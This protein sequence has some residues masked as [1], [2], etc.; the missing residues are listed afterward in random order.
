MILEILAVALPCA[1]TWAV[2]TGP[3]G[4]PAGPLDSLSIAQCIEMARA[5]APDVMAAA[6]DLQ[7]AR[8]DSSAAMLN[9]LPTASL[10]GSVMIAPRGFYDP[11][12]T[13]LGQYEFKAGVTVPLLDSG[14]AA[15]ER[16]RAANE[17]ALATLRMRS[18]SREAGL[19]AGKLA[20]EAL[21]RL[22]R[23]RF[24][25]ESLAWIE[26]FARIIASRVRAGVSAPSDSMRINIERD[27]VA[28]SLDST[29]TGLHVARRELA[30]LLGLSVEALPPI[31][32]SMSLEDLGPTTA[33]S[34]ALVS[35]VVRHPD[36][37]IAQAEEAQARLDVAELRHQDD[38]HVGLSGDAGIAG[39]DLTTWTPVDLRAEEPN[40]TFDDRLRRDLGVSATID[41]RRGLVDPTRGPAIA[42]RRS[43]EKAAHLRSSNALNAQERAALDILDRWRAAVRGLLT[44]R[45]IVERS[46]LNLLRTKSLYIAGSAG[47]LDILDARRTLDD[48]HERLVD[49]R[50]LSRTARIE[51]ETLP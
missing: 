21:T 39:T 47:M 35:R 5:N 11:T 2:G 25:T 38:L 17:A 16:A 22:E 14:A 28:A 9:S 42:A 15:R 44:T 4:A 7:A 30:S 18:I 13:D 37:A 48:A 33:D 51:A 23:E 40:P 10:F 46:E 27:M 32:E 50:S 6:A 26:D 1:A 8:Y 12:L 20:V 34:L 29:R 45:S 3:I 19:L 41:F 43:A 24:E 36:V 49:A 31:R